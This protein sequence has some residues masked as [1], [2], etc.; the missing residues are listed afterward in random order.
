[1]S[2]GFASADC[3]PVG[4]APGSF[5]AVDHAIDAGAE[6]AFSLLERLVATPSTVGRE[7]GAQEILAAELARLGFATAAVPV[8]EQ[9]AAR[10]PGGVAQLSYAG[11]DNLVGRLN[12]GAGPS[13]LLNGHIDVVPAEASRWSTAPYSPRRADG[14]MTGR[15]AGD[16]KGG[17]VMGLLAI[18][19]LRSVMPDSLSGELSF[20]SVIEEEC[21]GNGTLAACQAG[22][23]GDAVIMLEPTSLDLL[24]GGVGVLWVDVTIEG[25]AAHAEAADRAV[26]P[27]RFVP[28][29][30]RALAG[31]ETEMS[32]A[33]DDA[34]FS[35]VT[36]PYNVNPGTIR[37][38]D[39]PSSVPGEARLGVRVGYPRAWTPDQA[40]DRVRRA[41]TE[42]AAADPWLAEHPPLVR[43]SGYR[44]EGYLLAPDHPL[45]TAV[46]DAHSWAHSVSPRRLVMG[47]TTDA[48]YYINQ[49]GRPALA[50]GPRARNIHGADEAVELG[51]IVSGARTMARFIA[52]YF[53]A[54]GL[55]GA[56][57]AIRLDAPQHVQATADLRAAADQEARA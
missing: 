36:S 6:A 35:E 57:D 45:A 10:A 9:T 44:A 32:A 2:I 40:F 54:G 50:Y 12:Q 30:L 31:L 38:G 3:E 29:V 19:A 51:S 4:Y 21:T 14:W 17:F 34:A 52:R 20:L 33:R 15:G 46:S 22:V 16:M 53:A 47:S 39:W 13:L 48:R 41:I 5:E 43:P 42:A 55:P 11:R 56:P 26:N 27:V 28:M 49:F 37:A 18:E 25:V 1:V 23:L 24:L 8:P 7:A